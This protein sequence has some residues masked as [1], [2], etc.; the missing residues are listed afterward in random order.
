MILRYLLPSLFIILISCQPQN[1]KQAPAI[2]TLEDSAMV[3]TAHPLASQV[4]LD[5]LRKGGNA[6]DAAV[7]IQFSLSVVYPVAGNIGGGGFAVIRTSDGQV[8]ALDFREKAP[9]RASRD[10]YLDDKGNVVEG[11][12]TLGHRAAGI[13]GTVAGMEA[14][15][16]KYGTIPFNELVQPAIDQAIAGVRIYEFGA[17]NINKYQEAFRKV[18]RDS[19]HFLK[20]GEWADGDTIYHP[21]LASTLSFIRDF[22]RDGFYKGIVA[23][24]IEAESNRGGGLIT[25]EDLAGYE[26]R[27]REPVIG[28]YRGHKIIS[29]PPPS[30]GGVAIIQMLQGIE[31]YPVGKWGHN[32]PKTVHLMTEVERRVYADRATHLGDPD[33]FEVPTEMLL[34]E[35]YN[36]DRFSSISMEIPT[37]SQDIKEGKVDVIESIETTHF[38]VVDQWGNAASITTTLNGYFGCKVMVKGAGFFLNNEMD[39]FSSKPGVPNMFGLVGAEANAIMPE[40][41]MLS[42]MTPTIVEKDGQL[43]MVIGTPGGS[44]IITSVFQTILNVIDHEMTMQEAVNASKFHHQWLPDRILYERGKIDT[45][46]VIDLTAMGHAVEPRGQIGRMQCIY[47]RPDGKIEGASDVTRGY[48]TA[49]GF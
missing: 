18:N 25:K 15:H 19:I 47:I 27:W 5:V 10:M 40:K 37:S 26:A 48:G 28:Q 30:S 12:S 46:V 45:A 11:L 23:G 34:S 32:T 39:D 20:N 42:S 31:P 49:V 1:T 4:G 8:S 13:P 29:M 24:Q 9:G 22:G 21:E 7:A 41:R 36:E 3:V 38:S 16:Q 43:K 35:S 44:T 2:G 14:L 33:H 17:Y 6:I